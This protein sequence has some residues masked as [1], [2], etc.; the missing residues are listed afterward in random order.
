MFGRSQE[1]VVEAAIP[2]A[3]DTLE[4]EAA[5]CTCAATARDLSLAKQPIHPPQSVL[6]VTG[7]ELPDKHPHAITFDE[8]VQITDTG[9]A[10]DGQAARQVFGDLGR[11]RRQLGIGW[12]DEGKADV[13]RPEVLRDLMVRDTPN[14]VGI[15]SGPP[16]S[17]GI[18]R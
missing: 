8:L 14:E 6:V 16:A 17:S 13:R 11:G 3:A 10:D 18:P 2:L 4:V 7:V 9:I 15:L 1:P 12:L 5:G